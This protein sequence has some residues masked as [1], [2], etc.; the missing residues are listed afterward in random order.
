MKNVDVDGMEDDIVVLL[1]L[2]KSKIYLRVGVTT[3]AHDKFGALLRPSFFCDFPDLLKAIFRTLE[4]FGTIFGYWFNSSLV[5]IVSL[6]CECD[7]A[8]LNLFAIR[9]LGPVLPL[10]KP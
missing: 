3:I 7:M 4:L 10:I 6:V 8:F 2:S 5:H 1:N 9:L